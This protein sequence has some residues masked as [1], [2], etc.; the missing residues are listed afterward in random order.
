MLLLLKYGHWPL[1]DRD[2]WPKN[3]VQKKTAPIYYNDAKTLRIVS[4]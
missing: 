1:I 3:V 4:H 2:L